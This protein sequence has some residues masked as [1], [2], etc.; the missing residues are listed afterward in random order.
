LSNNDEHIDRLIAR[1]LTGEASPEEVLLLEQWMD[2]S[3]ENKKRFGAIRFVHDKT[4]ASHKYVKVNTAKAWDKVSG[5][6]KQIKEASHKPAITT[7]PLYKTPWFRIAASIVII[8]GITA[9][10]IISG[11]KKG[12]T[13]VVTIASTDSTLQHN[14]N[15]NTQ[16]VLSQNSQIT[17]TTKG[18]GKERILKL[19]GEAFIKVKHSTDT[20]LIVKADE[21]FIKDIGTSFNVKAFPESNTIEVYVESGEVIFYTNQQ[22]GIVLSKGETGMY[23]KD[24]KMFRKE[25]AEKPSIIAYSTKLFIFRNTKLSDVVNAINAVYPDAIVLDNPS[26]ADCTITVTFDNESISSILDII[27]ETIG[28][29]VTQTENVFHLDGERCISR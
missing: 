23:D 18:S 28:L 4:V 9:L 2:E 29:Q 11:I 7:R 24:T 8:I 16:V 20:T 5:Q 17:F 10:F 22:K 13:K 26:I 21:T 1:Y 6:M 12:Q 25:I 15:G 27:A 14:F 19:T 3:Y